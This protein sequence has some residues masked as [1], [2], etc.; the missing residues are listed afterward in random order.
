MANCIECG[1]EWNSWGG[2]PNYCDPACQEKHL[3]R[4][5]AEIAIRYKISPEVVHDV[6]NDFLAANVVTLTE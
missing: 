2:Y 5:A 4:V 6:V 1:R 3:Y